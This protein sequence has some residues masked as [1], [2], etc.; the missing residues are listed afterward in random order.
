MDNQFYQPGGNPPTGYTGG[1]VPQGGQAEPPAAPYG[2]PANPYGTMAQGSPYGAQ[3]NP[4]DTMAQGNPYV[5]QPNSYDAMAQGNPYAAQGNP[6]D[7]MYQGAPYAQQPNPYDAM[8]QGNPYDQM[9]QGNPYGGQPNPYDQLNGGYAQQPQQSPYGTVQQPYADPGAMQ[10]PYSQDGYEHLFAQG[11]PGQEQAAPVQQA[12]PVG[13]AFAGAA[14]PLAPG[15]K[16]RLSPSDIAL[17]VVAMLAVIGFAVWYIYTT[18]APQAAPYGQVATGSLSAIHSGSV[19]VVRNEIPYDAEGVN[20]VLYQAEEGGRVTRNT[21]ICSV[22]STGYSAS[23]VRQLQEYRDEIRTYQHSLIDSSTIRDTKMEDYNANVLNLALEIRAVMAG[24]E[25]SL[26]NI[27]DQLTQ[28]VTERQ[29][30]FDQLYASDQ[31]FSRMKDDER[32]QIQR[33][34]SWTL[35]YKATT[36]AL[37]SFYSDGYEYVINGSNYTTF[38]PDAIRAII[39][40]QKPSGAGP[41]KGSTTI[42]RLVKDNEWFALFLSDDTEWNPVKGETYELQLERFGGVPVT[43]EVVDFTKAGGELLVRLRIVGSVEQVMYLRTCD[44]VLAESMTT[45]VVNA[46]AIYMQDGMTGVVVKDGS[47]ESFIPVNVIYEVDGNAYF[48]TVQQGLIYEGSTVR[49]FD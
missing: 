17:I 33:I 38:G 8:A 19:L 34:N 10:A 2:A 43:A 39:N 32:S 3:G 22:Y 13:Q 25:G 26:P 29:L 31:R 6:Y 41:S 24:Y 11:Q 47:T 12:Q 5:Q 46:R 48:Q 49:L 28:V 14:V 21:V 23:A 27:E 18:Y 7:Q 30:Y 36:D 44:A 45:L 20:S 37:V 16:K 35:P 4:Y 15:A 40:G 1:F 42:Y 9:N